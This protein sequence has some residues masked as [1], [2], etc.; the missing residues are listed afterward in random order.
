VEDSHRVIAEEWVERFDL[1]DLVGS[2]SAPLI[3][4]PRQAR[5]ARSGPDSHNFFHLSHGQQKM[6]LLC[7]AM[8]KTPRMILLDEPTHGLSSDNR[9]R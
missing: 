7:R 8:V 3:K 4:N 9:D 5:A 1:K 2:L 6:V